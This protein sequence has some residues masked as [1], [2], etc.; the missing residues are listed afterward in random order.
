MRSD[1]LVFYG[2][3]LLPQMTDSTIF[4]LSKFTLCLNGGVKVLVRSIVF[5]SAPSPLTDPIFLTYRVIL[6]KHIYIICTFTANRQQNC[7]YVCMYVCMFINV[8]DID[9]YV[10]L[11]YVCMYVCM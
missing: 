11:L 3:I 9:M 8:V 6:I 4:Q 5:G 2:K 10:C 1:K 7:M